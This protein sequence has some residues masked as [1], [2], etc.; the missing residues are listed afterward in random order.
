MPAS[1]RS[2]AALRQPTKSS[3]PRNVTRCASSIGPEGNILAG[4]Q[5]EL[6][7]CGRD[8]IAKVRPIDER[9]W[10]PVGC[11]D[12]G[13]H[14]GNRVGQSTHVIQPQPAMAARRD[15]SLDGSRSEP[16]YSE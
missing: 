5:L 12:E 8:E 13:S 16:G 9:R 10:T 15:N 2:R 11:S 1:A 4:K 14:L 7:G 6:V 3:F